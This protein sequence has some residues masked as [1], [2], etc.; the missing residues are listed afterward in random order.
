MDGVLHEEKNKI[1]K[2]TV[3]RKGVP[4]ISEVCDSKKCEIVQH[5]EVEKNELVLNKDTTVAIDKLRVEYKK[6]KDDSVLEKLGLYF[7][8]QLLNHTIDSKE[9]ILES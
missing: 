3:T 4:V 6:T 7:A 5:A 9:L 8:N 1:K 2:I